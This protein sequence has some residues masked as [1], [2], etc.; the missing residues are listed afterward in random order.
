M[1]DETFVTGATSGAAIDS[2]AAFQI[3]GFEEADNRYMG[4]RVDQMGF[5]KKL[6][7]TGENTWL[8]NGG[9]GRAYSDL[10]MTQIAAGT[11][12]NTGSLVARISAK[13]VAG[14]IANTGA[15]VKFIDLARGFAGSIINTGSLIK[16]AGKVVAGSITKSGVLVRLINKI[17]AGS[18]T[19]AGAFKSIRRMIIRFIMDD[20]IVADMILDTEL[21]NEDDPEG[22]V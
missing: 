9:N 21:V 15:V 12:T 8:Y 17:A 22:R 13:V 20:T 10:E 5:W 14:I 6:L 4:G 3:G 7:S 11:I 16:R 2:A 19:N 1:D 18:I